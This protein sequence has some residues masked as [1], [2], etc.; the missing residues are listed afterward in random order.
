MHHFKICKLNFDNQ[1]IIRF[2]GLREG[3]HDFKFEIH[4]EFLKEFDTLDAEDGSLEVN[5]VLVKKSSFLTLDIII[6]GSIFLQ[7][8]R[9]LEY[10]DYPLEHHSGL[11]VKFSETDTLQTDEMIILNPNDNELDLKH[12]IYECISLGIPYRKVHPESEDG[13]SLC[14]KDM[15]Q[16]LHEFELKKQG[17]ATTTN[18]EKLKYY[19][20]N[21][22]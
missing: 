1:Y 10:F 7:C 19:F 14:K 22:N 16:K 11:V 4:K 9:C 15:I 12:Y 3:T 21:N 20:E 5:I 17:K 13:E 18:W 2:K 8:D 6:K